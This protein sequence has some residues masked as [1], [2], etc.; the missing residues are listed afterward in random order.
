MIKWNWKNLI[1]LLRFLY[2]NLPP[3]WFPP[4]I[5]RTLTQFFKVQSFIPTLRKWG[6]GNY[7]GI[8]SILYL[9][10]RYCLIKSYYMIW[11]HVPCNINGYVAW[12]VFH[13]L[14]CRFHFWHKI[15]TKLKIT[16]NS[17]SPLLIL[18]VRVWLW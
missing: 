15:S 4:L 16:R 6:W 8:L 18:Q 11:Q 3:F 5:S 9:S 10:V 12:L 14:I 7:M 17:F 1:P 13:Y 2:F